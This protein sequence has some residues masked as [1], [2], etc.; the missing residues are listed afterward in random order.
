MK[1]QFLDILECPFC[2]DK[3]GPSA[4]YVEEFAE[5]PWCLP[6]RVRLPQG[7]QGATA[8]NTENDGVAALVARRVLL[9][10]PQRYP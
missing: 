8:A 10:L 7:S 1:T 6:E 3:P 5:S 9:D 2:G 4:F